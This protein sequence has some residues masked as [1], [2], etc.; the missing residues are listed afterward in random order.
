MNQNKALSF[1]QIRILDL[2]KCLEATTLPIST[3]SFNLKL[4]DPIEKFFEEDCEWQGISG[5]YIITLGQKSICESGINPK[6]DTLE[7]TVNGFTRMWAG[8]L[9]ASSLK[10]SEQ[11][12]TNKG[13]IQKL[14]DAFATLPKPHPDWD[15]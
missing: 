1:W 9:P 14:D 12:I 13:L 7:T 8:V 2:F 6:L 3:F 10:L 4:I 11:F 5:E 15:F